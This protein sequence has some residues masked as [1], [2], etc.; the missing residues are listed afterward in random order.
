M[1]FD[2]DLSL[3]EVWWCGNEQHL[4]P[5]FE[6]FKPERGELGELCQWLFNFSHSNYDKL[7]RA[8]CTF[9]ILSAEHKREKV[10]QFCESENLTCSGYF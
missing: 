4:N 7:H 5:S 1:Y 2:V 8:T 3:N 10:L 9:K 6:M